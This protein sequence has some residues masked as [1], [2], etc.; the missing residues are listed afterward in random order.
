MGETYAYQGKVYDALNNAA[1]VILKNGAS[2][3]CD[4]I[5]SFKLNFFAP[6]VN[7]VDRTLCFGQSLTI[8]NKL[9]NETNPSGVEV[10]AKGAANGCDST[11]V[12]KLT[13]TNAVINAVKPTLCLGES[14]TINGKTYDQSKLVGADTLLGGSYSGCDSIITVSL[15]YLP[16][17]VG[18]FATSLCLGST[19]KVGNTVFSE[20]NP[21]GQVVLP[22]A[23]AN[24]CDSTVN[25]A[26]SFYPRSIG[27]FTKTLCAGEKITLAGKTFSELNPIDSVVVA[28]G[29]KNG[30]DSTLK[31]ALTYL[32]PV[33]N[34]FTQVLCPNANILINGS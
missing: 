4:S 12:V 26:V 21:S 22:K 14:F 13:F 27:S 9:Y 2:T 28:N 31:V 15:T 30:C 10:V 3:G 7:Q 29:S 16:A 24:G 25:V 1:Q 33:T 32:Q 20:A 19:V 8:N 18:S 11:I 34:N 6:V 23:S 5:I 17:A